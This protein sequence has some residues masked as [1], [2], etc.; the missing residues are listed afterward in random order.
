MGGLIS[1]VAAIALHDPAAMLQ[2]L[3]LLLAGWNFS[4]A[5][6]KSL[7]VLFDSET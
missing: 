6:A 5:E 1:R 2:H 3:H 7:F 4:L